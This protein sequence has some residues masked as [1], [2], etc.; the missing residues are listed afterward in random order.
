MS[1]VLASDGLAKHPDGIISKPCI[2]LL[3]TVAT[4]VTTLDAATY[5][6]IT[7][8]DAWGTLF[9]QQTSAQGG[10]TIGLVAGTV[11]VPRTMTVRVSYNLSGITVINA[12]T[13]QFAVFGGAAGTTNKGG[14]S[15][16][17]DITSG[18]T[19]YSGSTLFTCAA[20]DVISLKGIG[21]SATFTM[22]ALGGTLL[23]EEV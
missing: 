2:A 19:T 16:G 6:V 15:F 14:D 17:T 7:D 9:Q 11:T 1:L 12:A 20:G 10:F 18:P 3:Q 23:I 22:A 4:C 21:S 13:R 5:A 8:A